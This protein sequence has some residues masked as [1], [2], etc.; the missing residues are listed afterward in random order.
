MKTATISSI[1]RS[2]RR[3]TGAAAVELA[4]ILPILLTFLL[5]PIF[6]AMCFWH[7]TVAQ[8]AAQDAARYLSTVPQSEMRSP[9]L[10]EAA[11]DMAVEIAQRELAELAPG[12]E[13]RVPKAYCGS[14]I[15]GDRSSGTP[16]P[17]T[18]RVQLRF[19]VYDP[20][21]VVDV[22]WTGAEI[23]A[24]YTLRYVGN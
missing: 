19:S 12:S 15:C 24:N 3:Q 18:V 17:E 7:Y 13:I 1:R 22:G 20:F 6:Y 5:Y 21:G 4:L 16:L 2:K 8:K 11:G 9:E 10:A 14:D 23:T